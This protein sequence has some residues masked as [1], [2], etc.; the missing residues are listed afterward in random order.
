MSRPREES[1]VP[2]SSKR[3][4]LGIVQAQKCDE[5]P[6]E[7]RSRE[8]PK[9][10]LEL[11]LSSAINLEDVVKIS[12]VSKKWKQATSAVLGRLKH[13]DLGKVSRRVLVQMGR[14]CFSEIRSAS[15]SPCQLFLA[16]Y[17]RARALGSLK[18]LHVSFE[19]RKNFPP[20][21]IYPV[22]HLDI[23]H[24]LTCAP[25]LEQL[26]LVRLSHEPQSFSSASRKAPEI[27]RG[28]YV[29]EYREENGD[30]SAAIVY[31]HETRREFLLRFPNLVRATFRFALMPPEEIMQQNFCF[32]L[33]FLQDVQY[34]TGGLG[35]PYV[36]RFLKSGFNLH[37]HSMP[38]VVT[39][40]FD[41]CEPLPEST[42]HLIDAMT[43]AFSAGFLS[44]VREFYVTESG[45]R[46][47]LHP[48]EA[49]RRAD[50]ITLAASALETCRPGLKVKVEQVSD[51]V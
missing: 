51:C 4:C 42:K 39:L 26:H 5:P 23:D 28:L 12:M 32:Y 38:S 45:M 2:G 34:N 8:F 14:G 30:C 1:E 40:R 50:G 49:K 20:S 10:I 17:W 37:A 29:K 46:C 33:P 6:R 19:H 31:I 3:G 24:I 43:V 16:A 35:V 47:L 13:V 11:I 27:T 7:P 41:I 25:A 15:I 22:V 21:T 48:E 44:S 9:D 36:A 18:V